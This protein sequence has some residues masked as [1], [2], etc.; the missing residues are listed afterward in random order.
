MKCQL[1]NLGWSHAKQLLYQVLLLQ[2]LHRNVF[3]FLFSDF[4]TI[5]P[6]K[7]FSS[8]YIFIEL[9]NYPHRFWH[10][11]THFKCKLKCTSYI[12]WQLA[13]IFFFLLPYSLLATFYVLLQILTSNCTVSYS[14]INLICITSTFFLF[15]KTF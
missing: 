14:F 4:W 9:I 7:L 5:L 6:V 3:N 13:F 2:H 1:L 12:K 10:P 15:R 8:I 11:S